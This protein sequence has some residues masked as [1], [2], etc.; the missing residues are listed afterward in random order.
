LGK[1]LQGARKGEE[2][3][4]LIGKTK[5]IVTVKEIYSPS[6]AKIILSKK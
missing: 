1:I 5:R 2:R 3:I 6:I 4:L